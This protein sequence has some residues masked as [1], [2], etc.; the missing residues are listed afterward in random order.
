VIVARALTKRYRK[1]PAVD[2]LSF[3]VMG[4]R[5]LVVLAVGGAFVVSRDARW[6]A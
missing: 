5:C 1:T 2:D 3:E 6:D 4:L